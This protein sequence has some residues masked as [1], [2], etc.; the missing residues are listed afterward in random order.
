MNLI[1]I[2]CNFIA[3][4]DHTAP[5]DSLHWAKFVELIFCNLFYWR[6][7]C[8]TCKYTLSFVRSGETGLFC[9]RAS[10]TVFALMEAKTLTASRENK[11]NPVEL[12]YKLSLNLKW[13]E[14]KLQQ[15]NK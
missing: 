8:D 9:F 14:L 5:D 10:A 7:T 4:C 1:Y 11:E 6:K 15:R 12:F 2:F 13:I 3:K